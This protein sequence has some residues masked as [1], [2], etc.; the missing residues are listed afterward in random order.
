LAERGAALTDLVV[1]QTLEDVYFAAVGG[2]AAGQ[3][4]REG[5][6]EPDASRFTRGRRS[7]AERP[8]S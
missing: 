5:D 1:G 3:V 2:A 6:T 4:D 7:R 8:R